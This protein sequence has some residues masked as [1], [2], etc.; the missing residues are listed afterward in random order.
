M[1]ARLS[2]PFGHSKGD[3]EHHIALLLL[4]VMK[5]IKIVRDAGAKSIDDLSSLKGINKITGFKGRINELKKCNNAGLKS[6][7]KACDQ[8]LSLTKNKKATLYA[9]SRFTVA[10]ESTKR[11]EKAREYGKAMI[12]FEKTG[13]S[14]S[15]VSA[16]ED[17]PH[18]VLEAMLKRRKIVAGDLKPEVKERPSTRQTNISNDCAIARGFKLKDSS[19]FTI[20]PPEKDEWCY[21]TREIVQHLSSFPKGNAI[22][23]FADELYS[24][25]RV[26]LTSTPLLR[27]L[28][29]YSDSQ[30]L[31]KEGDFGGSR[32]R[33]PILQM[34]SICKTLNERELS[35]VSFV[36]D[37]L[38][39]SKEALTETRKRHLEEQ[40]LDICMTDCTPNRTTVAMYDRFATLADPEISIVSMET[41]RK[42]SIMREVM[43]RSQ[44]SIMSH[45]AGTLISGFE[46]G[47]WENKPKQL[48]KGAQEA[49][50]MM[51]TAIEMEMKPIEGHLICNT[52]DTGRFV[53]EGVGAKTM[54]KRRKTGK[55]SKIST[56]RDMRKVSSPW[57]EATKA[58]TFGNGVKCK[59]KVL[60]SAS[61]HVAPIVMH[62]YGLPESLLSVPFVVLE[63]KGLTIGGEVKPGCKDV[64]YVL[65]T[66]SKSKDDKELNDVTFT[67]VTLRWYHESV[68]IP[69]TH[70]LKTMA[71]AD[72]E[73][74]LE[75]GELGSENDRVKTRFKLDSD[76]SYLNY[77][78]RPETIILNR[79]NGIVADKHGAAHTESSQ[80]CDLGKCFPTLTTQIGKLSMK[81][82]RSSLKKRFVGLLD[83]CKEFTCR[84]KSISNAMIDAVSV[85]PEAYRKAF[86]RSKIQD[87]FAISGTNTQIGRNTFITCPNVNA[88][89][90]L[91]KIN[92][93]PELIQWFKSKVVDAVKEMIAKGFIS[94]TWFDANGF[95]KDT[96][97]DGLEVIKICSIDQLHLHRHMILNHEYVQNYFEDA[98]EVKLRKRQDREDTTFEIAKDTLRKNEAAELILK[99]MKDNWENLELKDFLKPNREELEAFVRVRKQQDLLGI[100]VPIPTT[101]GSIDKVNEEVIAD[102]GTSKYLIRWG[103]EC[104]NLPVIAND[105]GS[106]RQIT[107]AAVAYPSHVRV[108]EL[109]LE[110]CPLEVTSDLVA[111]ACAN[112]ASLEDKGEEFAI[113][114]KANLQNLNPNTFANVLMSRI[115]RNLSSRGAS[116]DHIVW[117]F[118]YCNAKL[119]AFII[120]LHGCPLCDSALKKQLSKDSL[121]SN[122]FKSNLECISGRNDSVLD[123][124]EDQLGAYMYDDEHELG[125]VRAGSAAV[126]LRKR[127]K[128]HVASS[129]QRTQTDMWSSFYSAYPHPG[130]DGKGKGSIGNFSQLRQVTGV[131][132]KKVM[133]PQVVRMFNWDVKTLEMLQKKTIQGAESLSEKKHRMVCYFFEKL[134]DLMIG[135][136]VNESSNAGF[137][138]FCGNWNRAQS[139]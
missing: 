14:Q 56:K 131:R 88:M 127:H 71:N 81:D 51:E 98:R 114:Q 1:Q 9:D 113:S 101:K 97:I 57:R 6:I 132:Y 22:K 70:Q 135:L 40:G 44:R 15:Q 112:F 68:V 45:V 31:P 124:I 107:I 118:V 116:I 100:S 63:V 58:D 20:P 128:A 92:W 41:T 12:R 10:E 129:R 37:G 16:L 115:P 52:D 65:L 32:G 78:R 5:D 23:R 83:G 73:V 74:F 19:T 90:K 89:I 130:D 75:T 33:S 24:Q 93:S 133:K 138:T 59:F 4:H 49:H 53:T 69:F 34:N 55:T 103:F 94:E 139:C 42:K 76:V 39:E 7:E 30:V 121:F 80:A 29:N 35:N 17:N 108:A 122:S 134:F 47:K 99:G 95:P 28:R 110:M 117:N 119:G 25:K 38:E 67:E 125:I 26:L 21:T 77:L 91:C 27:H 79:K 2:E 85:A 109:Q 126:G 120:K 36:G 48:P 18:K 62:F 8:L 104:K 72:E 105:P 82:D 43:S 84:S 123:N 96:T 60:I 106:P 46:V 50:T 102:D 13:L 87:S 111:R 86:T 66:R 137:E 54:D 136:D 61:G 3:R 64:G 11:I